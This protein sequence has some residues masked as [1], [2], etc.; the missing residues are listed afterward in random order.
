MFNISL[1]NEKCFREQF[2]I[3]SKP[4]SINT[5]TFSREGD[6]CSFN[7]PALVM[8]GFAKP[9]REI[10]DFPKFCMHDYPEE[11]HTLLRM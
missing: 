1:D 6:D 2:T 4:I 11:K 10:K 8:F 7:K 3:F 5:S 9:H